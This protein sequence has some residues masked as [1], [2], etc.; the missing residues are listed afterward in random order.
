MENQKNNKYLKTGKTIFFLSLSLLLAFF[1]ITFSVGVYFNASIER[2]LEFKKKYL[3]DYRDLLA[4][5]YIYGVLGLILINNIVIILI[6]LGKKKEKDFNK[7]KICV[8][9]KTL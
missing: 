5:I 3:L 2:V 4:S 7:K 6:L 9:R 1:I 8:G